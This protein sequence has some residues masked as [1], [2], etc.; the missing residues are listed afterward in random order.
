MTHNA[1]VI[2]TKVNTI[3]SLE[4]KDKLPELSPLDSLLRSRNRAI[5]TARPDGHVP[6]HIIIKM[7]PP[8]IGPVKKQNLMK[9]RQR[10]LSSTK[11]PSVQTS[12]AAATRP[13][14][15]HQT[16]RA[17]ATS[18]AHQKSTAQE[19]TQADDQHLQQGFRPK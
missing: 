18:Q 11:L 19:R 4:S 15:Q 8:T 16:P 1:Q 5:A 13:A 2:N 7:A 12:G 9:K 3:R 14:T 17:A 10:P 6:A